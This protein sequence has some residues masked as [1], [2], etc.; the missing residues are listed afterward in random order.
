LVILPWGFYESGMLMGV[1]ITLII[2]LA[3]FLTQYFVMIAA[4]KDRDFSD[5][6]YKTFGRKGKLMGSLSFIIILM[7]VVIIYFMLLSQYLYPVLQFFIECFTHEQ[8]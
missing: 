7:L 6:M 1:V 8:K 3:T 4:G 2:F 5:T